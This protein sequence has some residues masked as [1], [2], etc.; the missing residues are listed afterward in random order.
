MWFPSTNPNAL[1]FNSARVRGYILQPSIEKAGPEHLRHQVAASALD[2]KPHS[3][4]VFSRV[5][6]GST[7]GC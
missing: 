5:L 3:F 7:I 4:R 2:P 1:E 6:G